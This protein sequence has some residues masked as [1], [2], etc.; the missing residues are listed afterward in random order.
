MHTCVIDKIILFPVIDVP[1][2]RIFLSS[3]SNLKKLQTY[4]N[5]KQCTCEIGMITYYKE[6]TDNL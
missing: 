3:L 1:T 5:E 4:F 2:Y 6:L